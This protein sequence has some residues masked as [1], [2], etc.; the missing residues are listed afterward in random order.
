MKELIELTEEFA[1]RIADMENQRKKIGE[2]LREINATIDISLGADIF[3]NKIFIPVSKSN[4]ENNKIAGVDGGLVKHSLHGIDIMLLRAIGVIFNYKNDKLET[5][6]YYPDALPSPIPHIVFDPFSDIEFELNSN[7]ERQATEVNTAREAIEKFSPDI[8]LLNGSVVPH[9]TERPAEHSL[10]FP[11]YARMIDSYEQL[12]KTAKEK[13]TVLA[14]I[15]EDSRGIRFCELINQKILIA[16]KGSVA[17]DVKILLNKTKDSNLLSYA[18]QLN[19]RTF[20][21]KYSSQ[22]ENHPILREFGSQVA[23]QIFT[24]YLKTA[25][26]DRPIRID[27]IAEKDVVNTANKLASVLLALVGHSGYG[28]PSV[29][30][31]ADQRAKL[32]EKDL[33]TFYLDLVNKAGNI[34]SLFLQRREQRPF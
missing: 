15:I 17:T 22:P 30:I 31:E 21:F 5:A 6:D 13:W 8:M 24:F 4:L 33:E 34:P 14:G 3:E 11:T 16:A 20:V 28:M 1:K 23:N 12:F 9:Y 27:F 18:L 7:M 26:F 2:F 25:E 19:E 29:L 32:S 10:L